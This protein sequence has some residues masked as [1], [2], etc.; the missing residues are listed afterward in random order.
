MHDLDF[1]LLSAFFLP[2]TAVNRRRQPVKPK[3]ARH[4][5]LNSIADGIDR[6]EFEERVSKVIMKALH[7]PACSCPIGV[8]NQ[9]AEMNPVERLAF[10]SAGLECFYWIYVA[11]GNR[12]K[13]IAY[14]SWENASIDQQVETAAGFCTFILGTQFEEDTSNSLLN[15]EQASTEWVN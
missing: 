1:M 3:S 7:D 11:R 12:D 15:F 9:W 13:A 2:Q 8:I 14:P 4:L 10:V 5:F 6:S